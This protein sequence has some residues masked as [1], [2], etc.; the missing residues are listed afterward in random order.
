KPG[1]GKSSNYLFSVNSFQHT[2]SVKNTL[3]YFHSFSG[4]DTTFS[5][6]KQGKKKFGCSE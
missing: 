5:L 1:R 4:C 2:Q 3:L 6:S